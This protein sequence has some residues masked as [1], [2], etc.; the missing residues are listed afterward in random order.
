[1]T[2]PNYIKEAVYFCHLSSSHL[3]PRRRCPPPFFPN[4]PPPSLHRLLLL[5]INTFSYIFFSRLLTYVSSLTAF[6]FFSPPPSSSS[7]HRTAESRIHLRSQYVQFSS[8]VLSSGSAASR[9]EKLQEGL[10]L[11]DNQLRHEV[12]SRHQDLI[13]Q[14]SSLKASESS[15]SSLRSSL[16][17]LNSSLRQARS[18]LFDPHC[19]I[20]VQTLQLTN[21]HS[22]SVLVQSTIRILRLVRKL[23]NLVNSQPDPEK[24]DL[25]KAVKLHF[26][27]FTLYNKSHLSGTD[28]IDSEL[29]WVI[30]IGSK[31]RAEGMKI[32]EKGLE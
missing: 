8:V 17:S 25:P 23:Q 24:W 9:I 30:E 15:L 20:A 21:L 2:F 26:E 32:L 7:L 14:L 28:A 16:S 1:M 11:L 13:N 31:I 12:L 6:F 10:R 18:E 29:K 19:V 27:I 4:P 5:L 22:T 3:L